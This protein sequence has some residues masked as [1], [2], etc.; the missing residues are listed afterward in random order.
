MKHIVEDSQ[1]W[2]T[3]AV[4]KSR[5]SHPIPVQID[6]V[7]AVDL[8]LELEADLRYSGGVFEIVLKIA[9]PATVEIPDPQDL[10]EEGRTIKAKLDGSK[11]KLES[12]GAGAYGG[13]SGVKF[14]G[15]RLEFMLES[16]SAELKD[17]VLMIYEGM[18][19]SP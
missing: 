18:V 2:P 13:F 15:S 8:P 10:E 12:R 7:G 4:E 3:E 5:D 9:G 17:G 19:G 1:G 14:S 16:A 11:A 6:G